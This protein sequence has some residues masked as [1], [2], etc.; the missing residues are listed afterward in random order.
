MMVMLSACEGS[1]CTQGR[2]QEDFNAENW[3]GVYVPLKFVK[4]VWRNVSLL[5]CSA[6]A[7]REGSCSLPLYSE[8]NHLPFQVGFA[9]GRPR[10]NFEFSWV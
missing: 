4:G 7:L 3:Y 6:E 1:G 10:K 2:A 9:S 5:C 8:Q